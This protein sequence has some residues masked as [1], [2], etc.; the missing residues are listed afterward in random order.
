MSADEV[1]NRSERR[2]TSPEVNLPFTALQGLNNK[3]GGHHHIS[4]DEA[5]SKKTSRGRATKLTMHVHAD[6]TD[7]RQSSFRFGVLFGR[8]FRFA[9]VSPTRC[10][11]GA[12]DTR[13]LHQEKR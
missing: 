11:L 13:L 4:K 12:W 6:D 9:S 10:R 5:L 3:R 8:L 7:G 2:L 1:S